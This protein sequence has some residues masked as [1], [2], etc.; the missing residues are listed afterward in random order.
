MQQSNKHYNQFSQK[1]ENT[2]SILKVQKTFPL[3]TT[4]IAVQL[5]QYNGLLQC[6]LQACCISMAR[7]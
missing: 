2:Y 1:N 7:P 4:I 6:T 3:Q 5:L